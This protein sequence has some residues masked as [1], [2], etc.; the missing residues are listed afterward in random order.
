MRTADL[1]APV[2]V[3]TDA[4]SARQSH[5]GT[6]RLRPV[7]HRSTQESHLLRPLPCRPGHGQSAFLII[8][9]SRRTD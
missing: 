9:L 7:R 6:G 4:E 2:Q 8:L 3:A 5:L 1:P